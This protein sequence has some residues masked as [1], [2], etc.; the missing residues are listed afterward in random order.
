MC[1]LTFTRWKRLG[2]GLPWEGQADFFSIWTQQ[3][4]SQGGVAGIFLK[5]STSMGSVNT[6]L[7]RETD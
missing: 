2:L 1:E 6:M 7:V 4:V 5:T 3:E